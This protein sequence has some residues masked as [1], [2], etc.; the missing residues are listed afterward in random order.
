MKGDEGRESLWIGLAHVSPRPTCEVI[1]R[2]KNAFTN[3][4]GRALDAAEFLAKVDDACRLLGLDMQ[5]LNDVDSFSERFADTSP[6]PEI[7]GA[8][9]ELAGDQNLA[10]A[11]GTF[12]SYAVD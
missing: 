7:A 11:F 1:D 3:V 9:Q 8:I 4:V 6:S 2:N 12:Y 5:A 10:V